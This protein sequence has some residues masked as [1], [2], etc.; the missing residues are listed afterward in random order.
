VIDGF[1]ELVQSGSLPLAVAV[2][3]LAGL[4]SFFSPCVLPL[5]PGYLSYVSGVGVQDLGSDRRWRLGLGASLFVF[6]FTAVFVAGGAL[7][8]AVGQRLRPH[9]DV[10]IVIAGVVLIGLGLIF[11][12]AVP[13]FRR[14]WRLRAAPRVGLVAAPM[15]GVV[16]GVGWTPC[17]GPTLSAVLLLAGTEGTAARGSLLTAVYGLGLG[18][19]F[20]LAALFFARFMR[21]VGFIRRHQRAVSVFGGTLL[22]VTGVLMVSGL[23][24]DLVL[25]LQR[26]ASGFEVAV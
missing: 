1:G 3:A 17:L 5:L 12:G 16:F 9:G 15:L 10:L 24:S 22:I 13:W 6:G 26:W 2:A 21:A 25:H 19:P 11:V 8:G 4:V 7:F 14:E 20:I 23:W 18:I